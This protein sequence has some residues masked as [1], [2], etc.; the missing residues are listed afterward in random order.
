MC[1]YWIVCVWNGHSFLYFYSMASHAH[2]SM[3]VFLDAIF[4]LPL[5]PSSLNRIIS[6]QG[7]WH[8]IKNDKHLLSAL[9]NR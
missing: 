7:L 6:L 4:C 5:N 9:N 1:V 2:N 3:C 8:V